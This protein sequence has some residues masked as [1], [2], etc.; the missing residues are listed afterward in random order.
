MPDIEF[1]IGE[2]NYAL[3]KQAKSDFNSKALPT[4]SDEEIIAAFLKILAIQEADDAET[5]RE[6]KEEIGW[7]DEDCHEPGSRFQNFLEEDDEEVI[8][9]K[10]RKK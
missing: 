5:E 1:S 7:Y 2:H 4:L 8:K 10:R 6:L 9:P 3:Y